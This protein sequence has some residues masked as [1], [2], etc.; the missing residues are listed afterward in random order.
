MYLY[1]KKYILF[2]LQVKNMEKFLATLTS[3]PVDLSPMLDDDDCKQEVV[4]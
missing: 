1:I 3:L 2:L 4:Y